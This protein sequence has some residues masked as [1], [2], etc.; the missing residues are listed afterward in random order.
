MLITVAN[1][2]RPRRGLLSF[3]KGKIR[4]DEL[5]DAAH[6]HIDLKVLEANSQVLG[7][8]PSD[9][10]RLRV[11]DIDQGEDDSSVVPEVPGRQINEN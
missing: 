11:L 7:R 1:E 8:G 9:Y 4:V 5:C 2:P 3:E 10:A 6:L